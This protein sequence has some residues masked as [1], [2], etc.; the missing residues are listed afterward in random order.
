MVSG[1]TSLLS[2]G[3]DKDVGEDRGAKQAEDHDNDNA[4]GAHGFLGW[5]L[6]NSVMILVTPCPSFMP[7]ALK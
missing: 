1:V 3:V 5:A 4:Q 2:V 6:R 7:R